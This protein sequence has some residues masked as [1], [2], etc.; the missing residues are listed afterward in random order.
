M[1]KII[2]LNEN[3]VNKQVAKK[4]GIFSRISNSTDN[5]LGGQ[6]V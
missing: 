1:S 4:K 3:I 6:S 5:H 2:M